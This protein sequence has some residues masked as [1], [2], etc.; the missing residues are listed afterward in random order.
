[1]DRRGRLR[2]LPTRDTNI[3]GHTA[4]ER[5]TNLQITDMLVKI[6]SLFFSL[7]FVSRVNAIE[8]CRRVPA[9]QISELE[10]F[11]KRWYRVP[12]NDTITLIGTGTVDAACYR[13]LVFRASAPV[14]LLTLYLTPDGRHLV[15]QVMDLDVDPAIAPRKKREEVEAQLTGGT[16]LTQGPSDAALRLVEFSDYQC[17][18]CKRFAN[19]LTE[20]APEERSNLR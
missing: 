19:I 13:R 6:L 16:I 1:M 7:L 12:A 2:C 14:P 10:T 17:F 3:A 8:S 4:Y 20:L 15:P 9:E 11:V 18:Y 5:Y